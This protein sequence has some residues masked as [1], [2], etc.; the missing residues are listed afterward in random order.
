MVF[1]KKNIYEFAMLFY[2][3]VLVGLRQYWLLIKNSYLMRKGASIDN[4]LNQDPEY[5]DI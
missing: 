2:E 4:T 5:E 1:F 3:I